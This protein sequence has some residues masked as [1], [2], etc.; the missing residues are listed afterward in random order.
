VLAAATRETIMIHIDMVTIMNTGYI[1]STKMIRNI[2]IRTK[3]LKQMIFRLHCQ[4]VSWRLTAPF[5]TNMA[6]SEKKG[7]GGE[8]SLHSEGRPAIY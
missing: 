1:T 2:Y 6:I 7:Q 8:L 4:L 5:S 3:Q